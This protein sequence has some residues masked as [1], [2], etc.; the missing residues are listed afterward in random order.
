[1]K[2]PEEFLS[3][4][5][6]AVAADIDRNLLLNAFIDE[7][8]RG[9][10]GEKSSLKMIPAYLGVEGRVPGGSAAVVLD[11][12]GTNFRSG[13]V[14]IGRNDA[15]PEIEDK[16]MLPMPGSTAAV[17]EETF[18]QAFANEIQRLKP[19]G[20]LPVGWCFSYPADATPELDARLV[21]WTKGI[22]APGVV[23]KAVGSELAKRAGVDRI[24]VVNDTV[25]TLLAAK[26]MEG[27]KCY[28]SY[29][30]FIL[31][32]G[33]NVAYV[34]KNAN[35]HKLSGLE[36]RGSMIINAESGAFNKIEQ[37][38][39]D[40]AADARTDNAGAQRFEKMIA[41]A[42]LGDIVLEIYKSAAKAGYFSADV[43]AAIR[44]LGTLSTRHASEFCA[45]SNSGDNPLYS[46]FT[47]F[48]DIKMANRL[49]VP[50]FE[51]AAVLSAVHLAAFALKSGGGTD[52]GAPIAINADG[53]TFY[54]TQAVPFAD[55]V[56]R[57]LDEMLTKRRNV[58]FE[59]MPQ[60]K[61]APMIGAGIAAML[62]G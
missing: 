60:I 8:E 7:M 54:R 15:T 6:F 32:T 40:A 33:T 61:D 58:H 24:A 11:A 59:I 5:G 51:R 45:A 18:Y 30:G 27:E 29:I 46:I 19:A 10:R 22:R 13:I 21:A 37:S 17:D 50:V 55:V 14:R 20:A 16:Q 57:E 56:R 23:G 25:A 31:G 12:G 2:S 47:G 34:E 53:S 35:I 39:F 42:Y 26:A 4:K 1:M 28:S 52:A 9:L 49:G 43:A 62:R 38:A 36:P 44:G 3:D 48:E 41:G